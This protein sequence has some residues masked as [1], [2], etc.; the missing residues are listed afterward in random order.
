MGAMGRRH[1]F[2]GGLPRLQ[3]LIGTMTVAE[4]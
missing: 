1:L 2:H 3:M 4:W